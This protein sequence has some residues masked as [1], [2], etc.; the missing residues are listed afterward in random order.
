M[1]IFLLKSFLLSIICFVIISSVKIVYGTLIACL[2][3]PAIILT[4]PEITL[5]FKT[6]IA[7]SK[8]KKITDAAL[9][10]A[11]KHTD[12]MTALVPK[13]NK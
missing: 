6:F 5:V 10:Q 3:I 9:S 1:I 4:L 8:A 11:R 7:L 12:A 13:V 2:V